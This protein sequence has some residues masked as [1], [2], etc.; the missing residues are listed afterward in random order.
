MTEPTV[1]VPS[2]AYGTLD[3]LPRLYETMNLEI[4]KKFKNAFGSKNLTKLLTF[5][6]HYE[7]GNE[8]YD[9]VMSES[10]LRKPGESDEDLRLRSKFRKDLS[11]YKSHFYDY[12]VYDKKKL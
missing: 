3:D 4:P 12:S 11:K 5:V 1:E 7:I 8:E 10:H 2:K 6:D 9:Q